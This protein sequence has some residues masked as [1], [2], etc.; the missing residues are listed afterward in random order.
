MTNEEKFKTPEERTKAFETFCEFQ[1]HDNMPCSKCCEIRNYK[2][3]ASCEYIWLALEAEE[4]KPLPCPFCGG[5][6][7]D[8]Y[9]TDF[10][11]ADDPYQFA[12][13]CRSCKALV[14]NEG[15]DDAIAAWNRRAK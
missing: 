8:I 4:E 13:Q 15:K 5:S 11:R 1:R 9:E 10:G 6:D 7:I 12:V 2:G 14:S 3:E